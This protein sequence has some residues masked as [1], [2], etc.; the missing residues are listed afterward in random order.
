MQVLRHIPNLWSRLMRRNTQ[1]FHCTALGSEQ[2][3]DQLEQCRFSAAIG[4][5]QGNRIQSLDNKGDIRENGHISIRERDLIAF[6]DRSGGR[7][8]V[9]L[10]FQG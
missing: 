6:D 5:Y 3:K 8:G 9:Y 2:P 7:R 10:R 4:A 1:D